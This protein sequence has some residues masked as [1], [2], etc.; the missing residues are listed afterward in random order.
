MI[1]ERLAQAAS[2]FCGLT[3]DQPVLLGVSGG[4]DSLAMAFGLDALGYPLV[5]AHVDHA[6]RPESPAEAK[7]V[8]QVAESHG[9]PFFSQRIDV[10]QAAEAA[11]QSIEEAAR[12]VRYTYLFERARL[13][14][15][16]AVAVAHH[17][18]DQ[19]ETVLMHFLRGTALG[20][21]TGMS[22]R[23]L[24]PQ[25]DPIIPLVRPLLCIWRAEI[26]AYIETLGMTPCVDATNLDTTYFRN[27]LRYELIPALETYN[28]QVKT[29]LFRM[30]DVL[31]V[32]MDWLDKMSWAAYQACVQVETDDSI[33][34]ALP[35]FLGLHKALKR[36]VLRMAIEKLRPDL[37]DV[38][39]EAI[40]RALEYL[41]AGKAGG[42]IDL[43]ARL[44]LAV[45]EDTL[46]I[47]DWSAELPDFGKPLLV[48]ASFEAPLGLE[49]PVE[50]RHRWRL[51]ATV[52][53][54]FSDTLLSAVKSIPNDE[55]WLDYD[56]LNLPL[57]VRGPREGECFEPLGMGGHSQSLQDFFVNLKIT[58]HLR[59]VWPLVCADQ[60][61][62]WVVGLRPS[63]AFKI[64]GT[65]QR[66]LKLRLVRGAA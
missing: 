16:Q 39:F 53:E 55:A 8:Q 46:V 12:L 7:F 3:K 41:Q 18:D 28:P 1:L 65:T 64:T 58:A 49:R 54:D 13:N 56:R 11:N 24:M 5:I 26:D 14:K 45:I 40:E 15:C 43:I 6:L 42:E 52:E 66:V 20:G 62:A 22:Y 4:A 17:A 27:R 32:E 60:R 30:A 37:R 51:T 34:L 36:R 19:V 33:Q 35:A 61:A 2:K 23:R 10:R 47:K 50:L 9:W 48:D 63:E 38:G 57:T 44:N 59:P 31:Q 25:W 29:A 21:L